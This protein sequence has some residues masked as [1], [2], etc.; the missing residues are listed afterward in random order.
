MSLSLRTLLAIPLLLLPPMAARAQRANAHPGLSLI[1]H[2]I[3]IMQE[4]RSFDHY[5]GTFPGADGIPMLAGVPTVCNPDPTSGLCIKPFHSANLVDS[6]GPH[7]PNNYAPDADGGKMDGFVGQIVKIGCPATLPDCQLNAMAYHTDQEIPNYWSYARQ[8]VLQDHM[9]TPSLSWSYVEHNDMVSGWSAKCRSHLVSSCVNSLD[10]PNTWVSGSPPPIF[11]WTDITYLLHKAHVSWGYYIVEGTEPDC[12][13]PAEI[14][15]VAKSQK[16]TTPGY[17]NP[18]PQFDT[19]VADNE[20]GNVQTVTN[21]YAAATAGKLP[22]VSWVVPSFPVSEHPGTGGGS[23]SVAD[24][25][26]Y[27]TGVINAVMNSPN[28][29]SSAIFLA[30]DDFGGFYDHLAP[31][32]VDQNGY[33][34]RVPGLVISPYAK[35]GYIDHQVLSFDAYL[36]FIEDLF[37]NGQRLDPKT[38]GRPDPR[39]NVRERAPILGDLYNDFNFAQPPRPP[40]PLPIYPGTGASHPNSHSADLPFVGMAG[41]D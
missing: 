15:C 28:W 39:P 13:N 16:A 35:R 29:N 27:V 8:Y 7:A 37:L 21:F 9:F 23:V 30:W 31:P 4:N 12:L 36:K 20:L 22:S 41:A 34:F 6:G 38:D 11:A 19:V 33:G 10:L 2:V 3:I 40:T 24:G 17:W 25:Q 5:F 14:S 1:K 18:L 26:A 32:L